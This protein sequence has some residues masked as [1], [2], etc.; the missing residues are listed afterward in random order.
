MLL[1]ACIF[2]LANDAPWFERVHGGTRL[3]RPSG[4]GRWFLVGGW[5]GGWCWSKMSR[6]AIAQFNDLVNVKNCCVKILL[7]VTIL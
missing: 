1:H 5:V 3:K 6:F 2:F 4:V 7:A